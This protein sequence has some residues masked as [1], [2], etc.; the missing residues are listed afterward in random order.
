MFDDHYFTTCPAESQNAES[1]FSK[2]GLPG[3][4]YKAALRTFGD[5]QACLSQDPYLALLQL[6]GFKLK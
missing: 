1:W 4:M 2:Q 6:P 5:P 3:T